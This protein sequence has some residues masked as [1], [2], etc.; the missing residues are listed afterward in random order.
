MMK[1]LAYSSAATLALALAACG[2][3]ET[4]EPAP[5]A[6]DAPATEVEENVGFGAVADVETATYSLERTHAFLYIEVGHGGGISNYRVDFLDFDADLAFDAAA[7]AESQL[8]VTINPAL[9][10]TNYPGDYK[11]GHADSPYETW[12]ED[13]SRNERWLNSD[14]FPEISFTSTDIVR[15]GEDT[16]EV[17]GDLTFLGTTQNITLDVSFGGVANPPW[18]AG[19]DVRKEEHTTEQQSQTRN[20]YSVFCMKK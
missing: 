10:Q 1:L 2:T 8:S 14:T 20:S 12:D 16:G 18:F 6:S 5:S 7:P 15:T 19:R 4:S 13:I 3:A 17:K 9:V 11:A